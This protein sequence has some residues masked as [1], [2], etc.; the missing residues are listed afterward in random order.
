[1]TATEHFAR[2]RPRLLRLAYSELSD[3]GE[4]E[5]VVRESWLR[6]QLTDADAIE[7]LDAWLTTV[8]ARLALD[9]GSRSRSSPTTPPTASRSTSRSA[10]RC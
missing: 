9:H 3:V 6:L 10:T 2:A 7:N 1:M 5:D 8:V 4:A